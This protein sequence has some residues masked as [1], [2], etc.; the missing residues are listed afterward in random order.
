MNG[1]GPPGPGSPPRVVQQPPI[2]PPLPNLSGEDGPSQP[3]QPQQQQQAPPAGQQP[4]SSGPLSLELP[5]INFDAPATNSGDERRPL[6]PITERSTPLEG[7]S[8]SAEKSTNARAPSA[9]ATTPPRL[10]E[11]SPSILQQPLVSSPTANSPPPESKMFGRASVDSYA[12]S[13]PDSKFS[14]P[15]QISRSSTDHPHSPTPPPENS[16]RQ[17]SPEP[18]S[19]TPSTPP[20]FAAASARALSPPRAVSP[21]RAT[22][23]PQ[24]Q[25]TSPL[26]TPAGPPLSSTRMVPDRSISQASIPSI[27]TPMSRPSYTTETALSVTQQP[28][29][30]TAPTPTKKPSITDDILGDAGAALFYMQHMQQDGPV[31]PRKRGPPPVPTDDDDDEEET[32]SDS[33]SEPYTPPP[34][35]ATSPLRV[36]HANSPPPHPG[37][38]QPPVV[39]AKSPKPQ[40]TGQVTP[41]A[42]ETPTVSRPGSGLRNRPSGARAAPSTRLSTYLQNSFP[43]D[44]TPTESASTTTAA[45]TAS[46]QHTVDNTMAAAVHE[47]A[48]YEDHNADALA[49]LTFL[50][51]EDRPAPP[52]MPRSP[53]ADTSTEIPYAASPPLPE[54]VETPAS[55]SQKRAVPAAT[56]EQPR[57]SFAPTKLAAQRKAKT[58]AQQAAQQAAAHRPG[59]ANGRARAQPKSASAWGESSEEEEEEE[60]EEDDEEVDSDDEPPARSAASVSDHHSASVHTPRSPYSAMGPGSQARGSGSAVDVNAGAY[61]RR[62]RDLPQVPGGHSTSSSHITHPASPAS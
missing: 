50:E 57:S 33:E 46:R 60:E 24:S 15:G 8:L 42:T 43:A 2:L 20:R 51:Q 13:R 14:P 29:Q 54:V 12:G 22:S 32:P 58:Q 37:S 6:S 55:P 5:P 59:K 35:Q 47:S 10:P 25:T 19:T 23:P 38:P 16:R 44:T 11:Q 26:A 49:A 28:V 9:L 40:A 4:Q 56:S 39:P 52:P 1:V 30:S 48:S 41:T 3:S 53:P 7:R 45:S 17:M 31:P 21:F 27:P 18:R 36:Q 62:P 34:R 61:P